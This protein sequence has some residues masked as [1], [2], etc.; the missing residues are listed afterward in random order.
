M[1]FEKKGRAPIIGVLEDLKPKPAPP[2]EHDV[3]V[4]DG[5]RIGKPQEPRRDPGSVPK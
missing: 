1:A 3:A 4:D 5:P 2:R